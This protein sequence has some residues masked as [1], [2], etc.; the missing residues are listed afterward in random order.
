M[1]A[2]AGTVTAADCVAIT[3]TNTCVPMGNGSGDGVLGL[4]DDGSVEA[5]STRDGTHRQNG[6]VEVHPRQ[7]CRSNVCRVRLVRSM[8]SLAE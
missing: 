6:S 8:A 1:T 4:D 2:T 5:S 3:W 7:P